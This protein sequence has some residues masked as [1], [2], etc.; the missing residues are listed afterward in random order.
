MSESRLSRR[1][2][3]GQQEGGVAAHGDRICNTG[4]DGDVGDVRFS[5]KIHGSNSIF[6]IVTCGKS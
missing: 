4:H 3:S 1:S 2:G 5:Y 6:K